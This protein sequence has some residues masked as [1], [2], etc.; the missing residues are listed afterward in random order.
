MSLDDVCVIILKALRDHPKINSYQLFNTV[1]SNPQ[2]L[3]AKQNDELTG[4]DILDSFEF[5]IDNGFIDGGYFTS[6]DG[7]HYDIYGITQLGCDF[8]SDLNL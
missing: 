5:L 6:K 4:Q 2:F 1:A 8:L 7:P 3:L